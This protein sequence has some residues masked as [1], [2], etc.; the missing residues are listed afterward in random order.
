MNKNGVEQRHYH[1]QNCNQPLDEKMDFCPNCGQKALPEHLTVKYFFYE[2]IN[3]LF[4]FDSRFFNTIKNLIF[5]PSFLSSEFI[6]GR[7][8]GYIN[9]VQL[10]IF[11][12]TIYF[13]VNSL[14]FL[15]EE[16]NDDGFVTF[17]DGDQNLLA[18]S[19]DIEQV[20]SLYI[21]K[22]GEYADTINN[23]Y[24]GKFLQSGQ[25]FNSMD[26]E[27]QNEKISRNISY[28]VFLLMP[29]F[30]LYLGWFFKKK[31][32]RYLENIIFSLHFHAFYFV[33]GVVFLL[34]DKLFTGDAD[35][36]ILLTSV[37]TY[38]LVAAKRFYGFSW[39][40]TS[41]R[42]VGLVLIYGITVSIFMITSI[43]ISVL[44]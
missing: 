35:T 19:L 36:L 39:F 22:D 6:S 28:S 24:L 31:K 26:K 2:F 9:P 20:D 18:D 3:N 43:I 40:S 32:Q 33:A 27:S 5:K 4:S 29:L 21:I 7:R 1:C 14:M 42:F 13:L 12:S 17:T 41:V 8:V 44:F 30:A 38:L 37:I 11:S 16:A 25:D 15:K 10:F 23:S 34:L